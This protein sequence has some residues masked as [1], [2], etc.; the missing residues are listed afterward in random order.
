[1]TQGSILALSELG[2]AQLADDAD[3]PARHGGRGGRRPRP[4]RRRVRGAGGG[5]PPPFGRAWTRSHS[6]WACR[7]SGQV[8]PLVHPGPNPADMFTLAGGRTG[9]GG[10]PAAQEPSVLDV[11]GDPPG[12]RLHLVLTRRR[13]SPA[14]PPTPPGPWPPRANSWSAVDG[15]LREPDAARGSST[16]ALSPGVS[17][18]SVAS[19]PSELLARP[20]N[21]YLELIPAGVPTRHP[22]DIAAA[23]LPRLLRALHESDRTVVL[24]CPPITGVARVDHPRGQ[25]R[26]GGA[27]R[28]RPE[29]QLRGDHHR[30]WP[31]Y[32]NPGG[33]WWGSSSTACAVPA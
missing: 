14:W 8:P 20:G 22:A 24:D 33:T 26:R 2:P 5:G 27:G 9:P 23:D 13:G 11:P 21:R 7:S 4:H 17:D 15:D 25:G 16:C 30:A 12:H 10:V 32:G 1:M 3:E 29:A 6:D 18:I 28:R 31:R 19:G